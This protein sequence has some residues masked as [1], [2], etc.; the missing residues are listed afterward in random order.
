M[1]VLERCPSYRGVREERVDCSTKIAFFPFPGAREEWEK[2]N[3]GKQVGVKRTKNTSAR[4][5]S[6]REE[7][8]RGGVKGE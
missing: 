1:S 8:G 4:E 2:R 5:V 7:E 6:S 3:S